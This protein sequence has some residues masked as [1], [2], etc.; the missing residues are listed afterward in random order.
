MGKIRF[1]ESTQAFFPYEVHYNDFPADIV[2]IPLDDFYKAKRSPFGSRFSVVNN[3]LVVTEPVVAMP[4]LDS[5]KASAL[6]AVNA[7]CAQ[8]LAAVRSGYPDDEVQSWAKQEAEA[9]AY[10]ISPTPLLSALSAARGIDLEELVAKVIAK[11]DAFATVS[12][13]I[14]GTRQAC[15]DAIESAADV[16]EASAV[17]WPL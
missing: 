7:R 14:I 3:A 17:V 15:E 5:I 11:S 12:G 2:D 10:G 16:G 9:R 4:S 8:E 6:D 1:S 13:T